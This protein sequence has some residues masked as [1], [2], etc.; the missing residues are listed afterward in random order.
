MSELPTDLWNEDGDRVWLRYDLC[1]SAGKAR[2]KAF[3]GEGLPVG[4]REMGAEL[5]DLK[6]KVIF[7]AERPRGSHDEWPWKLCDKTDPDAV[8]FWEVS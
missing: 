4:F 3:T 7:A 2:Y 8:K 6:V 1:E 5:T